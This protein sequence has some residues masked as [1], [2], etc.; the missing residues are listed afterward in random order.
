MP[1]S[2]R[3]P[4]LIVYG[5]I[6]VDVTIL[7]R[8][9]PMLG[10]DARDTEIY[11]RPGGSAANCAV[12][13]ARLGAPVEFVGVT[14]SDYLAQMLIDDLQ[15]NGVGVGHLRR[16]AGPTAVVAVMVNPGGER[17][18][19]SFRGAA[20]SVPYGPVP[21]DLIQPGDFLHL[22]GY[23]FQDEHSRQTALQLI[24]LGKTAG[25]TISLD[26]S[27][28]SAQD[29]QDRLRPVMADIDIILP[30]SQ[31][32]G[33]MTGESVPERAAAV[34]RRLGPRIVVIKLGNEGCLLNSPRG[35]VRI[36]AYPAAV[37]D[38]TGAG[39]AF[40]G[41]F[42]AGLLSGLDPTEAA[43]LG[44]VAAVHVV[45]H[46]GGHDGAPSLAEVYEYLLAHRDDGLASALLAVIASQ[47][48]R[49]PNSRPAGED[50][51]AEGR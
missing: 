20:M 46:R 27:F 34:I 8:S 10:A 3:K 7:A 22:S 11:V 25:A 5:D 33:L 48:R 19:Y 39:D 51:K 23:S 14:G 9:I 29:F 26:P 30:N 24:A 16:T 17:T 21:P 44:H 15:D 42:L 37:V 35:D 2:A 38:T 47:N 50:G 1:N 45:A 32:A 6:A 36:R 40:C 41:G 12:A 18:F 49:T 13:A 31:E 4:R 28:H 43:R